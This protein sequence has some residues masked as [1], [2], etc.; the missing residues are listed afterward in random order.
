VLPRIQVNGEAVLIYPSVDARSEIRLNL[1]LPLSLAR[2]LS[3]CGIHRN[4]SE[5]NKETI[6]KDVDI[7]YLSKIKF[8]S[9]LTRYQVIILL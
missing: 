3:L 2:F 4:N 7:Y 8:Y 9:F 5:E 1:A 6:E